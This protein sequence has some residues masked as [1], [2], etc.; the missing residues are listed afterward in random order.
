[1]GLLIKHK[2]ADLEKQINN[3][4]IKKEITFDEL[5]EVAISIAHK[6]QEPILKM[7]KQVYKAYAIQ[8]A[9]IAKRLMEIL[10]QSIVKENGDIPAQIYVHPEVKQIIEN[11]YYSMVTN[12]QKNNPQKTIDQYANKPKTLDDYDEN[13]PETFFEKR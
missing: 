2:Y 1:M 10:K 9:E 5:Y 3:E 7:L 4:P 8:N 12:T 6:G 11:A 13:R